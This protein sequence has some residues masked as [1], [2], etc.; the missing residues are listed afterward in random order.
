M[1]AV[2]NPDA[3]VVLF[4]Y[5]SRSGSEG[6]PASNVDTL[7]GAYIVREPLLSI[8]T[9]KHKSQPAGQF[10]IAL[11]PTRNWT[12]FIAPGSWLF[13]YMC[14]RLMTN[15]ELLES[16]EDTLKMIGR[17]DSVRVSVSIDQATG[18]RQTSYVVVGRDWGQIF[19][20]YLY[21]D[22][23]AGFS[24]DQPLAQLTRLGFNEQFL[25]R[26]GDKGL[27]TTTDMVAF[28]IDLWGRVSIDHIF[29]GSPLDPR[30]YTAKAQ[31]KVPQ[32][33]AKRL[34]GGDQSNNL[35]DMIQIISGKL[36]A[37]DSYL[38]VD[39]AVGVP[40]TQNIIG[41]N[42]IWQLLNDNSCS[43]VNELIA[44]LR[45]DNNSASGD[46][47]ILALYK[48]IK[49]FAITRQEEGVGAVEINKTQTDN[50]GQPLV[51]GGVVGDNTQKITSSFFN[52][53]KHPVAAED[54]I[55]IEAGTNWRDAVNFIEV[56][57]AVS[58]IAVPSKAGDAGQTLLTQNKDEAA[59]YDHS[60]A[61]IARD[62]LRP[63]RLNS[64]ICP[65]DANFAP[66]PEGMKEWLPVLKN[67]YFDTHKMLNG[68]MAMM[69]QGTYVGV[70]NN[71]LFDSKLLG[72]TNY[73]PHQDT[74][75]NISVLAHIESVSHRFTYSPMAGRS[76]VTSV[77]F[78]RGVVT[79]EAGTALAAEG[80]LALTDSDILSLDDVSFSNVHLIK[81]K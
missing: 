68:T 80:L 72:A 14:P 21:I 58:W 48:R 6:I 78:V 53:R 1:V 55:S 43:I 13:I 76:F 45:W 47:P 44:D 27:L 51:A 75:L 56:L 33:I 81:G 42:T 60:G 64:R 34:A 74:S 77:S 4:N 35:A 59:V 9:V 10:E 37:P 49:P 3:A 25:K 5:F 40:D 8:T 11:A 20:S 2:R 52:L 70:G 12:A 71:V 31:F 57:A 54:V 38:D 61:M 32:V 73:L 24:T 66:Q 15:D 63:M 16:G 41:T 79:N 30:R 46:Q 7:S 67:W 18:T 69:G 62:G 39:E 22:P 29:K 65:P 36:Q 19:E 26:I 17:V 50:T 23:V 28:F